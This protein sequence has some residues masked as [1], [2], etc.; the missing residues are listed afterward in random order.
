MYVLALLT[1]LLLALCGVGAADDAVGENRIKVFL[2]AEP[3]F[4]SEVQ[5]DA[6]N[7]TCVSLLNN[8]IDGRV[9]SLLVGGHDVSTVLKRMDYWYCV[10]YDNYACAGTEDQNLVFPDGVNNL[11]SANWQTKIH[12]L[13]CTTDR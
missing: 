2:F 8:L 13:Q 11:A 1:A 6:V 3:A 10:F 12:S 5:V 4:F 9:Q 7:N